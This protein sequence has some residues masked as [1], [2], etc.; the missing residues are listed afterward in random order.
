MHPWRFDSE[1]HFDAHCQHINAAIDLMHRGE[2]MV[3]L[4]ELDAALAKGES[5]NAH[6]NRSMT[7]L[8]LGDYRQGFEEYESRFTLFPGLSWERGTQLRRDL[9]RWHGEDLDGKR[10]VV[11]HECGYGDT[12]MLLRLIPMLVARGIN[13]ALAMPPPLERLAS[14]LA[15][16]VDG[17]TERD[18]HACTYDLMR[19]LDVTLKTLP[20]DPYLKPDPMLCDEWRDAMYDRHGRK[21]LGIAWS[22]FHVHPRGRGLPLAQF[23]ELLDP[24]DDRALVSLQAHG[25][26]EAISNGLWVVPEFKDFADVAALTSVLDHV[27]S[28]DTAALHLAGALGHPDVTG[29]LPHVP[30]WRWN[31]PW[32]PHVKFCRQSARGDWESAFAQI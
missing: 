21:K 27:V 28:I 26:E 12:I 7:L 24:S 14:Q 1:A 17:L 4:N 3:A 2:W 23:L 22:S 9:P 30:C 15:P 13:V 29:V 20:T 16:L 11:V 19:L 18:V 10:L 25:R 6:W 8:A 31:A 32:Y 5:P